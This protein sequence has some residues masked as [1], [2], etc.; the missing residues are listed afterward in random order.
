VI[1]VGGGTNGLVAAA[2][3]ARAGAAVTL[4]E[5]GEHL[6]G[7]AAGEE[8][9]PGFK[10]SGILHDGGA[11]AREVAEA[12]DLARQGLAWRASPPRLAAEAGGKGILLE[13]D[14]RRAAPEIAARSTRDAE[15][16]ASLQEFLSRIEPVVR[17][18]F[19]EDLP[20]LEPRTRGDFFELLQTGIRL[21]RIGE[22]DLLQLLRAGPMC[23]EDWLA[24][25]FESPLLRAA[26]AVPALEATW[27]APSSAGSALLMIARACTREREATGGPAQI[28]RALESAVRAAGVRVRT[29][30]RAMRILVRDGAARG[31]VLEGGEE[32]AAERVLTTLDPRRSMDL[33]ERGEVPVELEAAVRPWR[34]RGTSA[35]LHL[36][37]DGPLELPGRAGERIEHW[38]TGSDP[39]ELDREF[40]PIKYGG[41]SERPWLDVR[42]PSYADP[43]LAPAGAHVASIL[44]HWIPYELA[45]GWT[46]EQKSELERRV[47][48]VLEEHAPGTRARIRACETLTPADLAARY[49]LTGGHLHHG[50]SSLDQLLF[51][52]PAPQLAHHATPIHGLYLGGGGT[53]PG[54]GI[55]GVPGWLAAKRML[56]DR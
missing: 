8:F 35:K 37:L 18:L 10:T 33:L 4:L 24:D 21:R 45:G 39:A 22:A 23:A 54:G 1:V 26:L 2:T 6:G 15:A 36:A 29:G 38:T 7:L 11:F 48:G 42:V 3:L 25:R 41:M 17:R 49:S 34:A 56:A 51:Q 50:E 44:A 5:R 20:P 32:L 30:T 12:L 52:R 43:S 13:A 28:A 16:H 19:R 47:L 40:A 55:T 14:P 53:H 27:L 31:V 46:S 9:H